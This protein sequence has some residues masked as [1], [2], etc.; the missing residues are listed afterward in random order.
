MMRTKH[1]RVII[2]VILAFVFAAPAAASTVRISAAASLTD[3]L[4]QAVK[5]Y[6]EQHSAVVLV[7]NFASSGALARQLVQG[8]QA[9]IYISANPKWMAYARDNDIVGAVAAAVLIRNSLVFVGQNTTLRALEDLPAASR[10]AY[11]S[12]KSTPVGRYAEQAM[13]KAGLYQRLQNEQRL[14]PTRDVRVALLY[15]ERGE[16]DGAFVYRTDSLRLTQAKILFS[17]DQN[18]YPEVVYPAA[19]T[20][21][22]EAN[23]DARDFYDWLF[24]AAGQAVFKNYGFITD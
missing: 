12:P 22:G 18:L 19:L 13:S 5:V 8:A 2:W 4:K 15:A 3:V 7:P 20:L 17:I 23:A 16:V 24:S 6:S 21:S 9:D 1:T 10:I 11:G 14:I